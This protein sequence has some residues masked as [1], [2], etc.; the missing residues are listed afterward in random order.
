MLEE[1]ND[2]RR[3]QVGMKVFDPACG[4][5]AF[6]VQCYQ[7]LVE[8]ELSKIRG[9]RLPP[10]EL[11]NLLEEHIFGMDDDEDACRVAQLQP[12]AHTSGLYRP[13]G[14]AGESRL[15]HSSQYSIKTFSKGISSRPPA[16]WQAAMADVK[17]GW[18]VEPI[19][20]GK[21]FP[22]ITWRNERCPPWSGWRTIESSAR[23]A[24]ISW[25]KPSRGRSR[26]TSRITELWDWSCPQ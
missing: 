25:P 21:T 16:S 7:W 17:L 24:A 1:L 2:C 10:S 26:S 23:P 15:S 12:D 18:I 4:S 8:R 13:A 19:R 6:L 9:H 3:L 5:G 20:L 22:Q 11:R 14:P